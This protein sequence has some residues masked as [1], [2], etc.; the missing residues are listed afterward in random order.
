MSEECRDCPYQIANK[1]YM[2]RIEINVNGLGTRVNALEIA[3]SAQQ[4]D[5]KALSDVMKDIKDAVSRIEVAVYQ[6]EDPFKKAIFDVGMWA[7][8]VL[9][10]GGALVWMVAE[11]GGKQ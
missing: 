3:F 11:F 8:K 10:G 4:R 9:I 5:V 7:I 6:R 1:E 2:D